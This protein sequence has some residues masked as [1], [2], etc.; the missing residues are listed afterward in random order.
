MRHAYRQCRSSSFR[1]KVLGIHLLGNMPRNH[2]S[3]FYPPVSW[4][5]FAAKRQ[6]EILKGELLK[7]RLVHESAVS[8]CKVFRAFSGIS[9]HVRYER[10][11]LIHYNE[12]I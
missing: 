10:Y 7:L 1:G 12:I 11:R 9:L 4:I 2:I 6:M 5:E 8:R 3:Q